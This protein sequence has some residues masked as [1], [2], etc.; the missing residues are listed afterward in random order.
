L[1]YPLIPSIL[2]QIHLS[3]HWQS[4]ADAPFFSLSLKKEEVVSSDNLFQIIIYKP[5]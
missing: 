4:R 3:S 2:V 1:V 5:N